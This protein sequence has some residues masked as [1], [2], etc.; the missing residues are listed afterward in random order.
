[1][2]DALTANA[3]DL[4]RDLDWL[5]S[6]LEMRLSAWFA[7]PS[8]SPPLPLSG[9]QPAM[10]LGSGSLYAA[11]L[12]RHDITAA[13]RL[14]ILLALAPHVRPHLLDVLW[15]RNEVTQRGFT[16][17][18]GVAG[19][20]GGFM[21]S[22]ETALFLLAGDD[23]AE[24]LKVA[25]MLEAGERLSRLDVLRVAGVALGEPQS[26]GALQVSQRFLGMLTRGRETGPVFDR[27]FPARQV[28]TGM[29]WEELVLPEATLSQLEEIRHWLQHGDT[30]LYDWG[31]GHRL[32]PGFTSLFFGPP[33]TG[34]TLSACLLGKL[35]DCEV[36][37]IDLSMVVSKYIG[38]T[39]KNLARVFDQAE[40][41]R[42]I[43]FFDEADA[44]FGKRTQV[45]DSHDR[46]ANQEV[47]FLLQR[48]EEFNGVV[49]LASN[50]K[51]NIDDAFMR[52]F[53]SVVNFPMPRAPER[54]RLWREA[55]P[56]RVTLDPRLD[57]P[58][59]A[60]RHEL[61]G[62]TIMNVA[63]YAALR[64]LAR[65]TT[66]IRAEDVEEGVRRELHKEGRA[67]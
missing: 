56:A 44:L 6:M 63:R 26:S 50:L 19:C 3:R 9:P 49:I 55:F 61:S 24:R 62:G 65:G 25:R 57:L 5:T 40:Y 48:I 29:R 21:P 13:E 11:F 14:I 22:A 34:K 23:L 42:W 16:E 31:M 17:F 45:S 53:Q 7:E 30:L 59:V 10:P 1:M 18:G 37:K 2:A 47:S 15:T 60:E 67:V 64:A 66:E 39:E 43:L 46:Y 4:A 36:Y 38:E 27:H 58:R 8:R 35:C 54:L 32:R 41:R 12:L 51:A 33:G 28:S 20:G 52:R